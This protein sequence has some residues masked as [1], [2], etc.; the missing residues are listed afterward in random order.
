MNVVTVSAYLPYPAN[1]G[2]RIRTLNLLTRLARRHTIT[3]VAN[4]CSDPSESLAARAFLKDHGM[5]VV[6]VEQAAVAPKKG[7]SFYLRLAAN[8]ASKVP[9]SVASHISPAMET[10]VRSL[11]SRKSVDLWQAEWAASIEA[12]KSIPGARKIV[13]AP[14]VETLIWERYAVNEPNPLKRWYIHQQASK[15]EQYERQTF[16]AAERVVTVTHDDAALV[17]ERFGMSRVD[18]VDNGIDRAYFESVK[19]A[20]DPRKILFLGSLDWRPNLDAIGLLLD[21]I[22]PKVLEAVPDAT[23]DI[24]GRGPSE[25]LRKRIQATPSALLH[26]DVADIR[27]YLAESG[28]MVVPLRIGGG[29]RLKILEA[30]ATGLPVIS[31]TVGAEGLE[32]RDGHEIEIADTPEAIA[33]GLVRSIR[34]P[35]R[36]A[37]IAAKGRALV[38]DRYDWDH[39]ADA[40]ERSWERCLN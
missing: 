39:L 20:R 29:S 22:F 32:L 8:L 33:Q 18:V 11:A 15:F 27:P 12:F 3:F 7:P 1:S 17:R 34:E 13:M 23:L 14:N 10:A 28:S 16:A 31:T 5:N 36:A 2:G 38:L 9:Y 30:L 35:Q 4:R 24:V 37:E 21:D 19:P 6:E 26:A 40:L 25:S